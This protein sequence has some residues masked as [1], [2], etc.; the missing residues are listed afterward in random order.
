MKILVCIKQIPTSDININDSGKWITEGNNSSLAIS[1]FDENALEEAILLKERFALLGISVDID[2]ISIG[3]QTAAESIK[4]AM[5]MG[6][7]NGIHVIT[8]D[9]GYVSGAVTALRLATMIKKISKAEN[10]IKMGDAPYSCCPYDLILTGIMSEDLMQAQ[11]G[12]MLAEYLNIPCVTSVVNIKFDDNL[13]DNVD[14]TDK[15]EVQRELE[16]GIRQNI[17]VK[18]PALLTIQAGINQPRYPSLSNILRANKKKILTYNIV[19]A[20][21]SNSFD[22]LKVVRVEYPEKKREAKLLNGTTKDKAIELKNILKQRGL[23]I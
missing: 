1:R 4:R 13:N 20:Q 8:E 6:A 10:I 3:S 15:I 9:K 21:S 5:G 7:D 19:D 16:G 17:K 11:V 12:P 18:L 2:I 22:P 23:L 14:I